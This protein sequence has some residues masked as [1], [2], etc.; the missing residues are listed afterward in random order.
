MKILEEG[1]LIS[2][3]Y[4]MGR[5]LVGSG[6][7]GTDQGEVRTE[8]QRTEAESLRPA[9]LAGCDRFLK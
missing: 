5:G 1:H 2:Q 8:S 9:N 6:K 3:I 7:E 4:K